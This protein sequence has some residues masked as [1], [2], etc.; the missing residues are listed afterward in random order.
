MRLNND[1]AIF[2]E[3]PFTEKLPNPVRYNILQLAKKKGLRLLISNRYGC[4]NFSRHPRNENRLFHFR[5][6]PGPIAMS[7]FRWSRT[8][9]ITPRIG[10]LS[11]W[12]KS[13]APT[14]W[15]HRQTIVD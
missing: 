8:K 4:C 13:I 7:M 2:F 12:E 11:N 15:V 14:F 5:K 3:S 6:I 1:D 10:K 9:G